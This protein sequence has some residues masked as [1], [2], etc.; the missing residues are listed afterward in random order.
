ME[1]IIE[2][3]LKNTTPEKLEMHRKP[4]KDTKKRKG[5]Q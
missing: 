3:R 5:K 1:E 2:V 4:G